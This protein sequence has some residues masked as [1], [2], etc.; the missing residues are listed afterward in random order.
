MHYFAVLAG[1]GLVGLLGGLR[2][3]ATNVFQRGV[4][5]EYQLPDSALKLARGDIEAA[6]DGL[7]AAHFIHRFAIAPEVTIGAVHGG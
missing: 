2:E 7:G 5:V 1:G 6:Q 3:E 4:L